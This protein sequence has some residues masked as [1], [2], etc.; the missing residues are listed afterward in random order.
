M[1]PVEDEYD[2]PVSPGQARLLV[3]NQMHPG[4]TQYHVPAA[5]VVLGAFDV[6]AFAGALDA[7]VARHEALRT[8]FRAEGGGYRQVVFTRSRARLRI[9]PG[10]SPSDVDA[11]MAAE[12]GRPFDLA[13]GPLLRCAVYPVSDGS[14][15]ILL[16]AHHLVCDGWSMQIMLRELAAGY[17]ARLDGRPDTVEPP[18]IQYPDYA[19]WLHDRLAA[20]EYAGSVD[21]W[22]DLLHDAPTVFALPTD[23][24]RPPVQT[25]A[26][27]AERFVLPAGVRQ[28]LVAVAGERGTTPF[29][30]LFAAYAAFLHRISGQTDLIVGVPVAGRDHPDLMGVV[31]LIT[32]TLA[33]RVDAAGDQPFTGLVDRVRDLLRAT[34]PHHEAPF[35]AVV[36]AVATERQLSYDPVVQVVF[37]YDDET[38]LALRLPGARVERVDVPL[39]VA[40]FDFLLYVERSGGELVGQFHYRTDLLDAATVQAWTAAFQVLLGHLLERPDQP[41]GAADLL[42]AGERARVLARADGAAP[43]VPDRLVP[44]LI[45]QTAA[46]RPDA[47]A[48]IHAGT[49][50]TYRELMTR[51]DRLAAALRDAGVGPDVP[52][53]LCLPRSAEMALAALGV[54]RA[55][56]AYLPL[57]PQT[58]PVRLAH[59]LA[60]AGAALVLTNVDTA[61]RM[62]GLD[63]PVAVLA[64]AATGFVT[65]PPPVGPP[66]NEPPRPDHT[67]YLLFTSGSTGTPKG[68]AVPHRALT[69]L[70]TAVRAEFG[71]TADDRVLQYVAF[72]FDVSVSD[73]VFT[74]VAGAQLHIAGEHERLG[75]AL[76]ARLRDSRI[77]YAFLPPVAAMSLPAHPGGLPELHTLVV[78]GEAVPAALVQRWWAPGRRLIDAYGPAE[79]TVY[80]TSAALAPR[81]PVVIG[82]PVANSRAYLL[83]ERLRPVPVGVVGEIYLAGLGLGRGYARRPSLTAERFLADPYGSPGGRMYRTGDLGRYSADG[84]L[85]YLGRA[86]SQVKVRGF[87]V[88]LGEIETTL[89]GHPDVAVAAA[90]VREAAGQR[91]LVGYVVPAGHPPNA[92]ELRAW[93][94]DRLPGYMMPESIV[95]L[96][97]LPVGRTG[98]VDRSRLPD[99]PDTRPDLGQ[100]YVPAS[101]DTQRRVARLWADVLELDR[102]GVHDNFFDLGGNSVRL[103]DVLAGL[104]AQGDTRLSMVDLFRYPTVATLAGHL[105]RAAPDANPPPADHDESRRRGHDRRRLLATRADARRDLD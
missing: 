97:R 80:A 93:L 39:G 89:A 82:R 21:V 90:T 2:F 69:N 62:V 16:T 86:D 9:E 104:R 56:G 79:A 29:V 51:A 28:R 31:G 19:A 92:G 38:D 32:N 40:K 96:D 72:S 36:E 42:D 64:E 35:S 15:R 10:H 100:L 77:T 105:D 13:H 84:T 70:A 61:A 34:G 26:G 52:V 18:P 85:T 8:A 7:L 17:T 37:A 23:R 20:G 88:E 53:G 27:A 66:A 46:A 24:P 45:A 50:L 81:E 60:D 99:P 41:I 74:W 59:M 1:A 49:V 102:V 87:R 33:L 83:D 65:P 91:R 67:A 44:D 48:L 76:Y 103:L 4:S 95:Y 6:S 78:G 22:R 30:V 47:T 73:L 63:V 12:A 68:V 71:V 54:L 75:D 101:T 5:F 55:G 25:T 98:K 3:L 94:A 57:D 14:H 11:A 43:P 58:P